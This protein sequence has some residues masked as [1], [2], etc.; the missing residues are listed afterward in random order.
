MSRLSVSGLSVVLGGKTIVDGIDLTVESGEWLGL[1]GPNGAGK[2]TILR[3]ITHA[4][5]YRG[6]VRIDVE[7]LASV[8]NRHRARVVSAVAQRPVVPEGMLVRDYVLLGRSPHIS[9]L[10]MESDSDLAA[11]G[12]AL[13]DLDIVG[14]ADRVVATLSGGELQKVVLARAVA[15]GAP[16]MLLDEPTASLDMGHAQ[17]V[18]ETVEMLRR[19]RGVTVVS[20]IHDLTLAAQFCDR[21]VLVAGGR[22]A[23]QGSARSVLTE[24][25]IRAHYGASVRVLDDGEGGVVVIPIRDKVATDATMRSVTP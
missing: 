15:Q 3:A 21:L 2:T 14:L 13:R 18:F 1:I 23:A 8:R 10:G 24:S 9:Y 11:A 4:V 7:D 16:V 22:I 25:S 12:E 6:T 17:Q 19:A 5:G 20:A